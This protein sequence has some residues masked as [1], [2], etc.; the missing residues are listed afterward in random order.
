MHSPKVPA[1]QG[2]KCLTPCD[3]PNYKHHRPNTRGKKKG[4][5][6]AKSGK[7]SKGRRWETRGKISKCTHTCLETIRT[8]KYN[9]IISINAQN[10]SEGHNNQLLAKNLKLT[11]ITWS[12]SLKILFL[13]PRWELA[14]CGQRL[15]RNVSE[16]TVKKSFC[17]TFPGKQRGGRG[18]QYPGVWNLQEWLIKDTSSIMPPYIKVRP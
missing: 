5:K 17:A 11:S 7:Q 18:E 3:Y 1:P 13:F 9:Q 2:V 10:K 4:G 12:K 15:I 16:E 14:G 6:S 8:I